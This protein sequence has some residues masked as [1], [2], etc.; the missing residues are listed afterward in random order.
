MISDSLGLARGIQITRSPSACYLMLMKS[1]AM[2]RKSCSSPS[3]G[4]RQSVSSRSLFL[5][6]LKMKGLHRSNKVTSV[7][8]RSLFS[9]GSGGLFVFET[10]AVQNIVLITSFLLFS[11][12]NTWKCLFSEN[13]LAFASRVNSFSNKNTAIRYL[14]REGFFSISPVRR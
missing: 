12:K 13:T 10:I 3:R 8:T 7:L 14:L 5:R 2:L 1:A 4:A 11:S 9:R 6:G